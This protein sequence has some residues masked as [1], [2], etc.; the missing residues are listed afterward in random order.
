MP[1]EEKIEH[2]MNPIYP[3]LI[4]ACILA[5]IAMT[6]HVRA[7]AT[8]SHAD[9]RWFSLCF[10]GIALGAAAECLGDI[11]DIVASPAFLHAAVKLI[12]F[13][14]TPLIPILL[15]YACGRMKSA[16]IMGMI[17]LVH[18]LVEVVLLPFGSVISINEQGIYERGNLYFIYVV[19]FALSFLYLIAMFVVLSRRFRQRDFP[20]LII[21][22]A[23]V[24][25]AVIPPLLNREVRTLFLGMSLAS[26]LLYS[27]YEGLTQQDLAA[28]L[29]S[30]NARIANMQESTIIGMANLIESRDGNTGEH[31]KN[32]SAYVGMLANAALKVRLYPG[33]ITPRFVELVEKAAPLHDVGKVVVPDHILNKPGRLTPEEYAIMQTHAAEGGAIVRRVLEGVTDPEYTEIAADIASYHH[34]KWDGTG[35]PAGLSGEKIPVAARIMAIADVYD[36]LISK[37]VYKD[38]VPPEKA[39]AIIEHDAG[40]HFDPRLATLFLDLM[41]DSDTLPTLP[42]D[43]RMTKPRRWT[44]RLA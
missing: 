23:V 7:N 18:A 21:T 25:V 37:R 32:T 19:P 1:Y 9:K 38:P 34:E 6:V 13:C 30:H 24:L 2:A 14:L 42:L 31:V 3:A 5:M 16:R 22:L 4:G 11:L 8:L 20:T 40:S 10:L 12:E 27:Y 36:A 15:A 33:V 35:Y 43:E 28:E 26:M 41:R 44:K 17:V 29:A 39:L